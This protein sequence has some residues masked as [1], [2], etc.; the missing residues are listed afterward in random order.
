MAV[1]V[2]EERANIVQI[3]HDRACSHWVAIGE[4][5]VKLT[6]ETSR[7]PQIEQ[8][9]ARLESAGYRVEEQQR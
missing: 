5:E 9:K 1:L 6:L 8:L 2:A 7:R 4:T 3:E